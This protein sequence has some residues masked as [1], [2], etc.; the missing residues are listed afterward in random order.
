MKI[1]MGAD[2][3]GY[4]LKEKVKKHLLE[5]GHEIIDL[6]TTDIEH[7][8]LYIEASDN[9]AKAV[10]SGEVERGIVICGTGMGVSIIA[11][12]HK[13]VYCACVESQWAARECR[14][15]NNCNMIGIGGRIFG[16]GMA[17]DT[18]DTFLSTP[19]CQAPESR[20]QNLTRLLNQ[21]KAF[22]EKQF[23]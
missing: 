6:G 9:V 15:V 1:A 22:E 19:F 21:I 23:I 3:L 11:N 12:K 16:E 2:N 14:T 4:E 18:V 10:Q 13:G 7:P 8:I 20:V 17:N 5:E